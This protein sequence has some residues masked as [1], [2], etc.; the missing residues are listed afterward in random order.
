MNVHK[1][2]LRLLVYRTLRHDIV[3]S[4]PLRVV[5]QQGQSKA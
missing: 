3:A 2:E 1:K 5:L 4:R